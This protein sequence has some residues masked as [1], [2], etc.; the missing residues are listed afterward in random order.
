[1]E[2]KHAIRKWQLEGKEECAREAGEACMHGR[3]NES[4]VSVFVMHCNGR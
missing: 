4:R 1:L 3:P 2:E